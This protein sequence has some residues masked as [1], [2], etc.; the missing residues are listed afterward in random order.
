MTPSKIALCF[1]LNY[2]HVLM[3][4]NLW[5]QWIEENK[6]IINVYFFYK[7]KEKISSPW[8]RQHTVP[9][10]SILSTS[11]YFVIPAYIS[12]MTVA[13]SKDKNNEWF[14][15]LT[16]SCCPFLSSRKFRELFEQHKHQSIL[17]WKPCSW[18]VSFHTRAN[19][20][21]L[22]KSL[23]LTN[24]P[25]FVLCRS[26]VQD[27]LTFCQSQRRLFQLICQGGLANESL[28]AIILFLNGKLTN[29]D[30]VINAHSH[31]CDWSRMSSK[32]SPY[33]FQEDTPENRFFLQNIKLS[34]PYRMFLRKVARTFPE[35][36]IRS[37]GF[38]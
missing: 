30:E 34:H 10:S 36:I 21:Y 22:P 33:V 1:I 23:H 11:Y 14:C 5:R 26:H 31:I 18:N 24:D 2:D 37:I 25:W 17:G 38:T 20:R 4:E 3:K 27:C 6:D 28:F 15:F 29:T 9:L 35:E 7:E 8:I 19:L 16:D 12:L 32:T 13:I